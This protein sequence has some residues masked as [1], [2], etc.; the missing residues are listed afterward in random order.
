[1]HLAFFPAVLF[2]RGR[3]LLF[4]LRTMFCGLLLF[5]FSGSYSQTVKR[6]SGVNVPL[7]IYQQ[8]LTKIG[9]TAR[10]FNGAEY[11]GAYPLVDGTPFW[12]EEGFQMGTLSYDG[13]VYFDVPLS[14]D[15]VQSEVLTRGLQNQRWRLEKAKVDSFVLAGHT[16]VHLFTDTSNRN[17]LPDDYYD[18]LFDGEVK[19][20]A[21]RLKT[22][23]RGLHAG[24]RD[25]FSTRTLYFLFRNKA[26]HPIS[27]EK[28]LLTVFRNEREALKTFWKE[29][30]LDFKNNPELFIPKTVA[31]W[32]QLKK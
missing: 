28:D 17:R 5:V 31:F 20:F 9:A 12:K 22:V 24:D 3:F 32:A 14:L 4:L 13:V 19:V 30:R 21:K 23:S 10:F 1:M 7:P 11:D 15:L 2:G 8:Y 25:S 18:R 6:D 26:Y 16:Y 29:N 27:R